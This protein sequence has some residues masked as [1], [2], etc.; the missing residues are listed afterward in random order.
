MDEYL[1]KLA[2]LRREA[3]S[4]LQP[5]GTR[6]EASVAPLRSRHEKSLALS[7]LHGELRIA[8]IA[9]QGRRLFG[10]M[11][12]GGNQGVWFADND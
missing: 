9:Q 12:S 7:R 8:G 1:V 6:P 11:G 2:L 5:G 3:E 4:R 10:P